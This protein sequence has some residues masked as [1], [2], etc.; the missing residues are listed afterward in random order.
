MNGIAWNDAANSR[1][2][3]GHM[4]RDVIIVV[5][6]SVAVAALK[7]IY[8]P[9]LKDEQAVITSRFGLSQQYSYCYSTSNKYH[10]TSNNNRILIATSPVL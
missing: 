10:Y 1:V 3:G 5:R 9:L 2:A 4:I 6:K 8:A 7:L